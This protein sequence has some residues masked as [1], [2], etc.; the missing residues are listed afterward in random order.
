MQSEQ[1]MVFI[2]FCRGTLELLCGNSTSHAILDFVS[3]GV[4]SLSCFFFPCLHVGWSS[5]SAARSSSTS[6]SPSRL[7]RSSSVA[8]FFVP[9]RCVWSKLTLSRHHCIRSVHD[10]SAFAAARVVGFRF[11]CARCPSCRRRSASADCPLVH[12]L[13]C[14]TTVVW[15]SPGGCPTSYLTLP[16]VLLLRPGVPALV[17]RHPSR[18]TQ[19]ELVMFHPAASFSSLTALT[20]LASCEVGAVRVSSSLPLLPPVFIPSVALTHFHAPSDS[21]DS[22][23]DLAPRFF[24]SSNGQPHAALLGPPHFHSSRFPAATSIKFHTSGLPKAS[25]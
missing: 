15:H 16:P 21:S 12:P 1:R 22:I 14:S 5:A 7:A 3:C 20:R 9:S 8:S 18:N 19:S 23:I 4:H 25:S 10:I 13:R 24:P 6:R 11:C 2:L 17:G